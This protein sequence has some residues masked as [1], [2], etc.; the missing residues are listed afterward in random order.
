M[1]K[2]CKRPG[3]YSGRFLLQ[4]QTLSRY[5]GKRVQEG[6]LALGHIDLLAS[7]PLGLDVG[8]GQVAGLQPL[9]GRGQGTRAHRGRTHR[10][11]PHRVRTHRAKDLGV[12][13]DN[14]LFLVLDDADRVDDHAG[15]AR[16]LGQRAGRGLRI[17]ELAGHHLSVHARQRLFLQPPG[18]VRERDLDLAGLAMSP[19]S[20]W[21]SLRTRDDTGASPIRSFVLIPLQEQ[22]THSA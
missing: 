6:H 21:M 1:S 13:S 15:V 19:R 5:L 16:V 17:Q 10:A 9:L 12:G 2:P 7:R 3:V 20:S 11:V 4:V 18:I 8:R 14:E 22:G